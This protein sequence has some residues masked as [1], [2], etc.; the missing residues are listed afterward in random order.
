MWN[1]SVLMANALAA[2]RD[3]FSFAW[4]N[5][6]HN[7]TT[8]ALENVLQG[9]SV[10]Q[11][12]LNVS[13]PAFTAFSLDSNYGNGSPS[14]G[15]CTTGNA[16]VGPICYVNYGWAWTVP[17]ETSTSWSTTFSNS[18]I[19]SGTC[20]TTKCGTS[21]TVNVTVRNPQAFKPPVGTTVQWSATGGQSGSTSVDGNGLIT[22]VGLDLNIGKT[23][24]KLTIP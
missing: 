19:T 4:A 2:C 1:M 12:R 11:L 10:P 15:D 24:L 5:D 20:P 21:A 22:V 3:G 13:Y 17:R 7:S 23:T 6:D 16:S 14:N 18:Q 8:A 9:Q